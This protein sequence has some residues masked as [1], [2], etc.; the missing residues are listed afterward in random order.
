MSRAITSQSLELDGAH[1]VE[2][3]G[4]VWRKGGGMCQCPAHADD[5]PSLS[6]RA[7]RTS[8][9]FKCF[10]GC[11]VLDVIRAIRDLGDTIPCYETTGDGS[12]R[13]DR[14]GIMAARA[15]LLWEQARPL[16]GTLAERYLA[17]RGIACP[18]RAL[19]FHPRTPLGVGAAVRFRPAMLAAIEQG[20][21]LVGVQRLF[22]EPGDAG[23]ARDLPRA[24]LMLGRPLAGAVRLFA[25]KRVLGLAEGVETAL[26]ASILLGLPVWA[27]LGNE[28]L[29]RIKIPER[30]DR[31]I[32]LPDADRAGHIA[33]KRARAAYARAGLVVETRWPWGGLNDWNDVLL[34]PNLWEGRE[35]EAG[36][37]RAA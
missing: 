35:G 26:S 22:L 9:L 13:S 11:D 5:T 17:G 1:L 30:I 36:V 3:L 33:A 34:R 15:V 6:V 27:T 20:N 14:S 7:G 31:L 32:L 19:R 23:P 29:A 10:A 8:L 18:S 12:D 24:K 37:R 4:G 21:R 25:P 28:R 2:R 16:S